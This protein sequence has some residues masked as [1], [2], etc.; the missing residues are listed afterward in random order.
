MVAESSKHEGLTITFEP[1]RSG[2]FDGLFKDALFSS[3]PYLV[4]AF[5]L[6]WVLMA[7]ALQ[8]SLL[9]TFALM[10]VALS[11]FPAFLVY[12]LVMANSYVGPY[13]LLGIIAVLG[14]SVDFI[15][16]YMNRWDQAER[17]HAPLA[18]LAKSNRMPDTGGT[19][20]E[21]LLKRV[22]AKTTEILAVI[23]QQALIPLH[24]TSKSLILSWSWRRLSWT[25]RRAA[26]MMVVAASAFICSIAVNASMILPALRAFAVFTT[27]LALVT[28][29]VIAL[30]WPSILICHRKYL[31]DRRC[32]L[33]MSTSSYSFDLDSL[34]PLDETARLSRVERFFYTSVT[35]FLHR[36][37]CL[38]V[39]FFVAIAIMFTV[40]AASGLLVDKR[41]VASA[42]FVEQHPINRYNEVRG[43]FRQV[44]GGGGGEVEIY[45]GK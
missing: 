6:T 7:C 29:L 33:V 37:G 9:A 26:S 12:R 16:A 43:M 45:G 40:F 19:V 11:V 44:R 41:A 14:L 38:V 21:R 27:I 36:R 5:C 32:C 35:M 23:A 39:S 17:L 25:F 1:V 22:R 31:E 18:I 2:A 15:M 28:V 13:H 8:S 4:S 24:S 42:M 10:L 20:S 30:L 3:V 34:D